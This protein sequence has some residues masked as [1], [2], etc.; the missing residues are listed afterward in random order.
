M[1]SLTTALTLN[2]LDDLQ[3]VLDKHRQQLTGT[4]ASQHSPQFEEPISSGLARANTRT[5]EVSLSISWQ[6]QD[7]SL[8]SMLSVSI[9]AAELSKYSPSGRSRAQSIAETSSSSSGCK[10]FTSWQPSWKPFFG[11]LGFAMGTPASAEAR[12]SS[13]SQDAF[14]A[15]AIAVSK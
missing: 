12:R 8:A 1:T 5:L 13:C 9:R 7:R 10:M 6:A 3:L 4:Q 11:S 14:L 15:M 2:A